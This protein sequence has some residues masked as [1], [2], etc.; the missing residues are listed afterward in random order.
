MSLVCIEKGLTAICPPEE[1]VSKRPR[2]QWYLSSAKYHDIR[3]DNEQGQLGWADSSQTRSISSWARGTT[4]KEACISAWPTGPIGTLEAPR[5]HRQQHSGQKWGLV[6]GQWYR[7]WGHWHWYPLWRSTMYT[8][9]RATGILDQVVPF[10]TGTMRGYGGEAFLL[11]SSYQ[12][13]STTKSSS[14]FSQ[15]PQAVE[16]RCHHFSC[17]KHRQCVSRETYVGTYSWLSIWVHP[18]SFAWLTLPTLSSG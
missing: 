7:H 15:C 9:L 6:N 12:S 8:I 16:P 18:R 11:G 4:Q 14:P 1:I 5:Q 2:Q 3:H 10:L 13:E 17:D